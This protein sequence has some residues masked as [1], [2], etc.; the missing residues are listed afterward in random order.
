ME[1]V[2]ENSKESYYLSLR[3]TQRSLKSVE[4]DWLPWISFFL[5]AV[6]QQKRNLEIKAEREKLLLSQLPYLSASILELVKSRGRATISDIVVLTKA[7][8]NKI[9]KHLEGLVRSG[10]LLKNGKGKG[11]WYTTD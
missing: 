11:T 5:K 4:T 9:K 8:R 10:A 2:I 7:N 3:Q 1:S 6:H